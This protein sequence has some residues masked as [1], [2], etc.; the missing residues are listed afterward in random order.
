MPPAPDPRDIPLWRVGQSA[1]M[2]HH[3]LSPEERALA[4]SDAAMRDVAQPG[5]CWSAPRAVQARHGGPFG[6]CWQRTEEAI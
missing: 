4:E 2:I 3:E 1:Y 6:G 5:S